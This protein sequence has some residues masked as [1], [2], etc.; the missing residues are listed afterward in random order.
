M[1]VRE[2]L[3]PQGNLVP[4]EP[5]YCPALYTAKETSTLDDAEQLTGRNTTIIIVILAKACLCAL[6]IA[7]TNYL[8][9]FSHSYMTHANHALHKE[10]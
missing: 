8:L 2:K 10:C 1:T 9:L 4:V 5:E 3:I 6:V 7:S